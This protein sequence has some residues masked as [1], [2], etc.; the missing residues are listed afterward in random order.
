MANNWHTGKVHA[1]KPAP[2][3]GYGSA[4]YSIAEKPAFPNAK[5]GGKPQPGR[6]TMGAKKVKIYPASQG[7]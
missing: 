6:S 4:T 3:T 2:A 1:V 5:L 7:V